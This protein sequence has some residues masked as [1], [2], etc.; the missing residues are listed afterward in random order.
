MNILGQLKK[1]L[2]PDLENVPTIL[3]TFSR[4]SSPISDLTSCGAAAHLPPMS[5]EQTS[6][7]PD[8]G[9]PMM[10]SNAMAGRAGFPFLVVLTKYSLLSP[11]WSTAM[12]LSAFLSFSSSE[13]M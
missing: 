6:L 11:C 5:L 1:Q 12:S 4:R 7:K 3:S 8:A 10:E 9:R 13:S 2:N